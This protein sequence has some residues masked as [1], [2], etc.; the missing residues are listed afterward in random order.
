MQAERRRAIAHHRLAGE[1]LENLAGAKDVV[2]EFAARELHR[3]HVAVPM[4][5][6]LVSAVGDLPDERGFA[7]CDP[8]ED[9][10]GG[11]PVALSEE[12]EDDLGGGDD[13]SGNALPVG[14]RKTGRRFSTWNH[15]SMSKVRRDDSDRLER[16]IIVSLATNVCRALPLP[17]R[18]HRP[19]SPAVSS[20][21]RRAVT[22]KASAS[23]D[24]MSGRPRTG[25]G[26][27]RAS[28][29]PAVA[30]D[31]EALREGPLRESPAIS[32]GDL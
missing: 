14:P 23:G 11:A 17:C 25:Q 31:D 18:F 22:A 13:A 9:E 3:Q 27:T 15:S 24:R 29:R 7:L 1:I 6:N 19:T 28:A 30:V 20:S 16:E 8:A 12:V 5:G 26:A 21:D 4:S 10:E 2:T 32:V